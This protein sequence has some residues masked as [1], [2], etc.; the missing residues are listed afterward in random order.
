MKKV[1]ILVQ[2][3]E[4]KY[5]IRELD[6]LGVYTC[7]TK[8]KKALK[9]A[10]KEDDTGLFKK[11]GFSYKEDTYSASEYIFEVGYIGLYIVEKEVM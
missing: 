1:F 8:A 11:N 4:D 10:R 2:E 7:M 5:C 9:K 6:I 3:H